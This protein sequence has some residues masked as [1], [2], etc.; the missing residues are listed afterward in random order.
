[1]QYADMTGA[2]AGGTNQCNMERERHDSA[3]AA[4]DSDCK[5]GRSSA[6]AKQESDGA[7]LIEN[8]LKGVYAA[9]SGSLEAL[10]ARAKHLAHL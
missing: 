8:L 6:M 9:K 10:S 7:G 5:P 4:E 3:Q 2:T 1:M